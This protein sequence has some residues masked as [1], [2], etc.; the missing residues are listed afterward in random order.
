[1]IMKFATILG[2]ALLAASTASANCIGT[3]SFRTCY[4]DSGNNYTVNRMGNSTYMNGY[5]SQTGSNWSQQTHTYGN[6]T[7]QSGQDS[8]GNNW[9]TTCYKGRCN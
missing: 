9:N 7:L 4:D 1:M 5:N 2:A 3:G 6:T 8:R